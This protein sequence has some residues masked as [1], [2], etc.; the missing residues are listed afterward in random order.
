MPISLADR[1]A[2]QSTLEQS[3]AVLLEGL[4]ERMAATSNDQNIQKLARALRVEQPALVRQLVERAG[5]RLE[6]NP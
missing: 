1:V 6:A 4:A 5:G 2:A 3:L